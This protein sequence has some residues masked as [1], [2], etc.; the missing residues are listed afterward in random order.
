[1]VLS[2]TQCYFGSGC[3][4]WK[5]RG[6]LA[7]AR[8][9]SWEQSDAQDCGAE[10]GRSLGGGRHWA[11]DYTHSTPRSWSH[12]GPVSL[13][14][15]WQ[16]PLLIKLLMVMIC[17]PKVFPGIPCK[18]VGS[19]RKLNTAF[20]CSQASLLPRRRRHTAPALPLAGRHVSTAQECSHGWQ[21]WAGR[22]PTEHFP[23]ENSEKKGDIHGFLL[24]NRF[25]D[26]ILAHFQLLCLY[27]HLHVI[28]SLFYLYSYFHCY[29]SILF[30]TIRRWGLNL[31]YV[32]RVFKTLQCK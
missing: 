13:E 1:M 15:F 20:P 17:T 3:V 25:S 32:S 7:C 28:I 31:W 5:R 26:W 19:N 22:P 24:S 6:Q 23:T 16:M 4:M 21:H 14:P 11:A 30:G 27:I 18:C 8:R 12:F 2:T 29:I 10:G 9:W